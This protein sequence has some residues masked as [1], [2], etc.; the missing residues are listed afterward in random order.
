M[1]RELDNPWC[2]VSAEI[3]FYKHKYIHRYTVGFV[4]MAAII[5]CILFWP[6]FKI[7]TMLPRQTA[8]SQRIK[9][10]YLAAFQCIKTN[11]IFFPSDLPHTATSVNINELLPGRKY[12][13]NVYEVTDGR[14]DNLIL[15]TSQTT[16]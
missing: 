16:G 5:L 1:D 15:T 3:H 2:L 7:I 10:L 12:T 6:D 13:V 4:L 14:D 9:Y 11:V 8:L